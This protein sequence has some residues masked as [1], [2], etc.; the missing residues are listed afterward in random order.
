[1]SHTLEE[2]KN[3]FPHLPIEEIAKDKILNKKTVNEMLEMRYSGQISEDQYNAYMALWR[4]STFRYSKVAL[5][6]EF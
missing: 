1:M 2:I 6:L 5:R 4:N 3:R